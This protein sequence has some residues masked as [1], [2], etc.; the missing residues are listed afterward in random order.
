MYKIDDFYEARARMIAKRFGGNAEGARMNQLGGTRRSKKQSPSIGNDK[1]IGVFLKKNNFKPLPNME[2]A[3]IFLNNGHVIHFSKPKVMIGP[4]I[5]H[6]TVLSGPSANE[7]VTELLPGIL[8]QL[9]EN[10]SEVY[11]NALRSYTDREYGSS[12]QFGTAAS[13]RKGEEFEEDDD[14]DVP[15]LVENFEEASMR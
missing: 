7:K 1:K 2:E 4:P 10:M 13:E 15:E 6:T 9:G 3:N 8:N 11:S 14:D 5:L 12:R